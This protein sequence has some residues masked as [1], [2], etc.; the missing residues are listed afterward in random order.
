MALRRPRRPGP[1]GR[2][3]S[4]AR[5]AVAGFLLAFLAVLA[6][7]VHPVSPRL[8]VPRDYQLA[9][10]IDRQQGAVADLRRQLAA[11]RAQADAARRAHLGRQQGETALAA[12]LTR[13]RSAAGLTAE[14]GP[15][16]KVTLD[17]STARPG[18]STDVNDLVIHSQDVQAVV[19]ALWRAGAEAVAVN[20]QRL[21]ATSAVLCVGNTLLLDGTVSSPPYVAVALG[22]ADDRFEADALV[23]EL[24]AAADTYG[25]GFHVAP[26]ADA[27]VP[28]YTGPIQ[29]HYAVPVPPAAH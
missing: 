27:T 9:G 4:N 28:A 2:P 16:L 14:R 10:L 5:R 11:V 29:S 22:A 18:P 1:R 26:V 24:H 6:V 7:R 8:R 23:R 19:N 15:G 12:A 13:A 17:D 21:V 25:L 3:R 20:G